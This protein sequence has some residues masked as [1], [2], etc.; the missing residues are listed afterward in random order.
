MRCGENYKVHIG[1]VYEFSL[2]EAKNQAHQYRQNVKLG[3]PPQ[4]DSLNQSALSFQDAYD[5]YIS[6]REF[7]DLKLSYLK[8]FIFRMEKYVVLTKNS[9]STK[10]ELRKAQVELKKIN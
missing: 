4:F 3:L 1:S 10:D 5:E 8:T 9:T 2:E 7:N 6:S